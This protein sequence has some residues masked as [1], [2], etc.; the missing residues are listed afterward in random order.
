MAKYIDQNKDVSCTNDAKNVPSA[1]RQ[2]GKND[3]K[4]YEEAIERIKDDQR[5][6]CAYCEIDIRKPKE[7][8]DDFQVE[9]F[10]PQCSNTEKQLDWHNLLG[11]CCGGSQPAV[12]G[13]YIDVKGIHNKKERS[14]ERHC[15]CA[16]DNKNPEEIKILNPLEIPAYPCLFKIKFGNL[17][18]PNNG[19]SITTEDVREGNFPSDEIRLLVDVEDQKLRSLVSYETLERA[20]NS[21]NEFNLN[22]RFLSRFRYAAVKLYLKKFEI[23]LKKYGDDEEAMKELMREVYDNEGDWPTFF[24]TIRAVFGIAAEERLEEINYDG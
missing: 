8:S 10:Q 2:F 18:S 9:H 4:A 17:P 20:Q 23:L 3:R 13:R 14:R 22:C 21:I 12:E 1:W 6:L 11:I 7:G 15:G 16:K 19:K 24:T 5:G